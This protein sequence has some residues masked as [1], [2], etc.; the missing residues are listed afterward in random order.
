MTN[1]LDLTFLLCYNHVK[2]MNIRRNCGLIRALV[3]R[4]T[5]LPLFRSDTLGGSKIDRYVLE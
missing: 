2:H 3:E 1:K 5:M 4:V